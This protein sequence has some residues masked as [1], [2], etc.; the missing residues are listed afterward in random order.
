MVHWSTRLF[1]SVAYVSRF[2]VVPIS[3][4]SWVRLASSNTEVQGSWRTRKLGKQNQNC[5]LTGGQ[6]LVLGSKD[7]NVGT[8]YRLRGWTSLTWPKII[9][10]HCLF[11]NTP[12]IIEWIDRNSSRGNTFKLNWKS[13]R[14]LWQMGDHAIQRAYNIIWAYIGLLQRLNIYLLFIESQTIILSPSKPC[15]IVTLKAYCNQ[16]L[17]T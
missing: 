14:C 8:S 2:W 10:C 9:E 12:E 4:S 15:E 7:L 11:K 13:V 17:N 1:T 3:M 5:N 6:T 16:S